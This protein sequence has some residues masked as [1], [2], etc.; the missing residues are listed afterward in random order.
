M[1]SLFRA[2]ASA[3]SLSLLLSLT[4]CGVLGR[5]R[6]PVDRSQDPRIRAEV[7]ARLAREP[8]LEA[9][10]LR[11]AV[12]GAVVQLHGSVRGIGAWQC[13]ITNAELVEGVRTVVDYLVIERGP[14]DVRCLAPASA[15]ASTGA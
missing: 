12:D 9:G 11:V 15:P 10:A 7:E 2:C 8:A 1:V 5:P 6:P 13:A 3:T 4:G 14:R